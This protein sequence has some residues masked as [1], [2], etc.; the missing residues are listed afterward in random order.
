MSPNE[1]EWYAVTDANE[2]LI[3]M[4]RRLADRPCETLVFVRRLAWVPL[5]YPCRIDR[6][7]V[8]SADQILV[9]T[10]TDP[11]V[12]SG[13]WITP[14]ELIGFLELVN[15]STGD[16][17]IFDRVKLTLL[18][19]LAYFETALGPWVVDRIHEAQLPSSESLDN[20]TERSREGSRDKNVVYKTELSRGGQIALS[21]EGL[22]VARTLCLM[23]EETFRCEEHS[24]FS[25]QE[26]DLPGVFDL[27]FSDAEAT[28][29]SEDMFHR[30]RL[31]PLSTISTL[32]EVRAELYL[33]VSVPWGTFF[34]FES[35]WNL[36]LAATKRRTESQW[37][38]LRVTA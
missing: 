37:K 21:D 4:L 23:T 15:I 33:R 10:E 1:R 2:A 30:G 32:D 5:N 12:L 17:D 11:Q 18:G 19:N 6:G 9:T 29:V 38:V 34:F 35:H 13:F 14:N 27:V 26:L 22:S 3:R 20:G 16:L 31:R 25:V 24:A 28:T 36:R 7:E 8:F